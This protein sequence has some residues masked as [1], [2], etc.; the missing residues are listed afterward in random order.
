MFNFVT[1]L[2]NVYGDCSNYNVLS[3]H[4]NGVLEVKWTN[5][6]KI[7]S[8]SA[9]KSVILWD[10]NR[11]EKIR[12]YNSH[13]GIINSCSVARDTP[14]IFASGSDD[15][16]VNIW[17]EREKYSICNLKHKYQLTSVCLSHDGFDVYTGGIDNVIRY[18]CSYLSMTV[19][20]YAH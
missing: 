11:G 20:V 18:V 14:Q 17:D 6:N 2:W 10:A 13:F 15:C 12:K 5:T 9:D 8:C 16:S 1:V 19:I 4:K 7:V 3:G